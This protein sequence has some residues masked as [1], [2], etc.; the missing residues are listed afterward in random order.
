MK[1]PPLELTDRERDCAK[2]LRRTQSRE[3]RAAGVPEDL[4]QTVAEATAWICTRI[5]EHRPWNYDQKKDVSTTVGLLIGTF[6]FS[7]F[8]V[9]GLVKYLGEQFEAGDSFLDN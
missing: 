2:R 1:T 4:I 3:M 8:D 6:A 7:S 9:W 5:S